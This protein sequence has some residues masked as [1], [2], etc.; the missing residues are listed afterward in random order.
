MMQDDLESGPPFKDDTDT[1]RPSDAAHNQPPVAPPG[2]TA[3][4][5]IPPTPNHQRET[6]YCKPELT[7]GWKIFLEAVAGAVG[8]TLAII[9]FLQLNVMQGQLHQM[10]GSSGQSDQMICLYGNQ[11][12]GPSAAEQGHSRFGANH[13]RWSR[14]GSTR[15]D[16]G[17]QVQMT[18]V[19]QDGKIN[20]VNFSIF[21]RN[22]GTTATKNLIFHHNWS[23]SLP[24]M[25]KN[26]DF[27]DKWGEG[28]PHAPTP[29]F[30]GP[31]GRIGTSSYDFSP[32]QIALL[33]SKQMSLV[34]WGWA[35]YND[36]FRGTP[37]HISRYCFQVIGFRGDPL[38]PN[39]SGDLITQNC[40]RNNC[41]DEE[42]TGEPRRPPTLP[43]PVIEPPKPCPV[44]KK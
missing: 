14:S 40:D 35:R 21:W 22:G 18:R 42:C 26:F 17:R 32:G 39:D 30:A 36:V 44:P 43:E 7:P 15:P 13:Q 10:E 23:W 2:G 38:A 29:S 4:S 27:K 9:Y 34:F 1:E 25:P 24:V 37:I 33:K 12:A 19:A 41:H 31:Q 28:A 16:V 20:T 6:A 8:I 3:A 11:T 5:Q